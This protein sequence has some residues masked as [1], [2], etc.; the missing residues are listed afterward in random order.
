M[1]NEIYARHGWVFN[2]HDL[3]RY[4]ESQPW[5]R[6][7]GGPANREEANH[8]AAADLS[9]LEKRNVQIIQELENRLKR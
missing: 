8:L 4:F 3:R 7:K 6:P 5:Y 9:A 1:R 2:R